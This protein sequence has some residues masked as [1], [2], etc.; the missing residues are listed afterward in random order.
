MIPSLPFYLLITAVLLV[1][2]AVLLVVAGQGCHHYLGLLS[3]ESA[4]ALAS[5][6]LAAQE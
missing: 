2:Q 5:L 6:L 4:T 1:Q 3:A